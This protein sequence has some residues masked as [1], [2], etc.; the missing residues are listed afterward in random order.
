M[1][2]IFSFGITNAVV[3]CAKSLERS[4]PRV[5]LWTSTSA[6]DATDVI[7]NDIKKIL[8]NGWRKFL[9]IGKPAPLMVLK[10][11]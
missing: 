9:F 5:Y 7:P 6:A 3:C 11:N 10:V 8:T 2:F 4:K 1:S